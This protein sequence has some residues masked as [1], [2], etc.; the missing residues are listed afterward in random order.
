VKDFQLAGGPDWIYDR[1]VQFKIEATFE[2]EARIERIR[3]MVRGLL[4][5]RFQLRLHSD[6]REG[7]LFEL[8]VAGG[9]P[10][11]VPSKQDNPTR[12]GCLPYPAECTDVSMVDFADYLSSVVLSQVVVDRTGIA[13]RYDLKVSW[14]P[15]NTQFRGNGGAGFFSGAGPSLFTAL[16]EQAGLQLRPATGNIPTLVVDSISTP[17][18]N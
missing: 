6:Q 10:K 13:G 1:N 4:A 8:V 5:S 16:Q 2:G 12:R 15:D 18:E 3:E 11:A 17:S 14:S 7:P 9:G